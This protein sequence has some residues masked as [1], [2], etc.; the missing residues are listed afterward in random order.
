MYLNN[1]RDIA[2]GFLEDSNDVVAARCS[3]VCNTAFYKL[4]LPIRWNLS[5]NVDGGTGDDS[6][7]LSFQ[8]QSPSILQH[9]HEY[10][11]SDGTAI[12]ASE[13]LLQT[14]TEAEGREEE[15]T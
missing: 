12:E 8:H 6:L 14:A 1:P 3:L 2:A 5:R 13:H 10:G 4:A 7:G 11:E 15:R 9:P